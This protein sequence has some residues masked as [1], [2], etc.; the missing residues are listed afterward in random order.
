MK[1]NFL[2]LAIFFFLAAPTFAT[3]NQSL[4][5]LM[6]PS[7][8][9][10]EIQEQEDEYNV[11]LS[12]FYEP[13]G[14]FDF[15]NPK[16]P[17]P[18]MKEWN[19]TS[20]E[21]SFQNYGTD[22]I[23]AYDFVLVIN[24]SNQGPS[25]QTATAYY[26]GQQYL[27]F[28]VSTGRETNEV[29]RSGKRY[30]SNTPTGWFH[31]TWLSR[32]HVSKTW[33]APMPFAVFFNGG[34]ATHAALPAYFNKLGSRASGG[35]VRFHPAQA[36]WIF[37]NIQNSGKGLVP[38]FTRTGQPVLDKNGHQKYSQNWRSLIIVVNRAD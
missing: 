14:F 9:W 35:C 4:D 20:P 21:E 30:F 38:E 27:P 3:Q 18:P 25:A 15:L 1:N 34:I 7:E 24:K 13:L 10:Q 17:E 23:N 37:D 32:N 29:S 12:E 2:I 26:R 28:P 33:E 16:P 36:E 22:W 31:P 8:I 5:E 6:S 11:D 19:A